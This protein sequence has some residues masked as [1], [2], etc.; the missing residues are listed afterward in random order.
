M[1]DKM[2]LRFACIVMTAMAVDVS[3][4]L[5]FRPDQESIL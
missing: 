5:L 2:L 3:D 4:G 1:K